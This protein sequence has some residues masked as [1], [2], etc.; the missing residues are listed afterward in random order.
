MVT[1]QEGQY[2]MRHD[3]F[4][5]LILPRRARRSSP[6][7]GF[8]LIGALFVVIGIA[9]VTLIALMTMT[10]SSSKVAVQ[11]NAKAREVR[12]ADNALESAINMM[13][14]DA[15][16]ELGGVGPCLP[17]DGIEFPSNGRAVTVTGAC[18]AS[19]QIIRTDTVTSPD[20]PSVQLVGTDG[21]Q[22][23]TDALDWTNDCLGGS[24]PCAPWISGIGNANYSTL[25]GNE[26]DAANRRSLIHFAADD[27]EDLNKTLAIGGHVQARRGSAT[28]IPESETRAPAVQVAGD[29]RQADPGLF[30]PQS[31]TECGIMAPGHPWLAYGAQVIDSVDSEN[32]EA[33]TCAADET[34]E[35]ELAALN[36]DGLGTPPTF[37]T[38]FTT[39]HLVTTVPTTCPGTG[40][41]T[42]ELPP[43]AYGK[44]QTAALNNLLDGS[45]PDHVFWF[46]PGSYWFDVDD[47]SAPTQD[48]RHSLVINDSSARVIFGIPAGGSAADAAFPAACDPAAAGVEIELSARTTLRHLDGRVAICDLLDS[49]G[50]STAPPAI[51]QTGNADGGWNGAPVGSVAADMTVTQATEDIWNPFGWLDDSFSLTNPGNAFAID[52]NV[53]TA[54]FSCTIAFEGTCAANA[55]M[56]GNDFRMSGSTTDP[57]GR[58][59]SLDVILRARATSSKSFTLYNVGT[60]SRIEVRFH[61]EEDGSSPTCGGYFPYV[62][63][64]RSSLYTTLAM[65]LMSTAAKDVAGLTHCQA[66]GLTRADLEGA[67]VDVILRLTTE[68]RFPDDLLWLWGTVTNTIDVD[69]FELRAGWDLEPASATADPGWDN[70]NEILTTNDEP[71]SFSLQCT[72]GSYC[73]PGTQS[74]QVSG[75]DN[76][77]SPHVPVEDPLLE[78]DL[79]E[80]GVIVTGG[81]TAQHWLPG[82]SGYDRDGVP[83]I[84]DDSSMTVTISGLRDTPGESCVAS[85]DRVPFWGQGV[86]LDLLDS[87]VAGSCSSV[88]NTAEQLIGASA[89]LAVT[90]DRN[91]CP[92]LFGFEF[93]PNDVYGVRI[94]SVRLST[95]T[96]GQYTRP[97]APTVL[98][99]GNEIAP[100]DEGVPGTYSSFNVFGRWSMPRNDLNVHWNGPAPV[101]AETG[102]PVPI[103]GGNTVLSGVASYVAPGGE[104]GIL[105]CSPTKPAERIVN[106]VATVDDEGTPR[107]VGTARVVIDDDGGPGTGLR[108]EEWSVG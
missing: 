101:D 47:P 76:T 24:E 103:G 90:V 32:Q 4:R 15:T 77:T 43:G 80:A 49:S 81:T 19:P 40:T 31:P 54:T 11:E 64:S 44:A 25:A 57:V 6:Q 8:A 9:G 27:P 107:V 22:P 60:D 2:V 96:S 39:A 52:E 18:E 37:G 99:I 17:E 89:V 38:T 105:C 1:T 69:G 50:T 108:I 86:Y 85:W 42:V 21:Y 97:P 30:A 68:V 41:T 23:L 102:E 71:S 82:S 48:L 51:W 14:M 35:A 12:A 75:F 78:D 33:P 53:A 104:A 100:P 34:Y 63:D 93:C 26:F 55:V 10:I 62:P 79:I 98:T 20:A 88:L 65:D 16:G 83:S 7:A 91:T 92:R 45:C 84:S 95:V 28:L 70:V 29:Y 106:L 74:I 46:T 61:K 3:S 5:S 94:D 36:R 66:A 73:P 67:R 59:D 56:Q 13:R 87:S 58:L 72:G